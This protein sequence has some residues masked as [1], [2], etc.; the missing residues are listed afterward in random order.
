MTATQ[1]Q[2]RDALAWC[3]KL[4]QLSKNIFASPE[5]TAPLPTIRTILQSA[6]DTQKPA[7]DAAIRFVDEMLSDFADKDDYAFM[8][9]E[10]ARL[11][12]IKA[13][14]TGD[15]GGGDARLLE[16][17]EIMW[18]GYEN[19]SP[20]YENTGD[21]EEIGSHIGNA[22]QLDGDIENEIVKLL[23]DK[24]PRKALTADNAKRGRYD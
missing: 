19:G 16:L 4:D 18:D 15:C 23:N 22:F 6:L 17:L 20:C 9:V 2:I 10:K 24:M 8:N 21:P 14:L 7:G 5:F 11:V 13:A 1:S 3:D 12:R